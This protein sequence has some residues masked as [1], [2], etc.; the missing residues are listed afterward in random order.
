MRPN[1]LPELLEYD[2]EEAKE[3]VRALQARGVAQVSS[4]DMIEMPPKRCLKSLY[5]IGLNH[6]KK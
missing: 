3:Y 6:P 5:Q 2:E 1:L 4:K